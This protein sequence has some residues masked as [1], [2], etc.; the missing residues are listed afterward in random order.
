MHLGLV[1]FL[2][3]LLAPSAP[4]RLGGA[5]LFALSAALF[6]ANMITIARSRP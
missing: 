3:G 2:T 6:A 1:A 4:L 5:I